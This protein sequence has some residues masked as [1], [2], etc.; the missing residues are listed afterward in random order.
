MLLLV[1]E[2]IPVFC[3]DLGQKWLILLVVLLVVLFAVFFNF[4]P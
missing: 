4:K 2:L 3:P 1:P